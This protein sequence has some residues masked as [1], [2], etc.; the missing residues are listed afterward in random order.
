METQQ[1]KEKD[2]CAAVELNDNIKALVKHLN[3]DLKEDGPKIEENGSEYSFGGKD[4]KVL[5]DE[6]ADKEAKEYILDSAWAF[7][8]S[9]LSCHSKGNVDDEVFK[10]LSEKCESANDAVLSLIDDKDDFVNDAISS[11][12]RGH[13]LSSYDSKEYEV[14]INNTTYYIYRTS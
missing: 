9:F 8:S 3:L 5:T 11:D 10:V 2:E 13:F 14:D 7:N 12:G 1:I 4:Y 6:E